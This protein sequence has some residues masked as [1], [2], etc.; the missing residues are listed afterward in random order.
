MEAF[1]LPKI[2]STKKVKA[3]QTVFTIEPLYPGYGVTIGN[4]LRRVLLSSLPGAAITAVKFSDVSHEFTTLPYVKEDVVDILLNLKQIRL[5]LHSD[6]PVTVTVKAHGAKMVTAGDIQPN[7]EVEVIDADQPIATLTDKAG[8]FEAEL[9]VAMG[10]G[11]VPVENREK[12]KLDIGTIALD[13]IYTPVKNVNFTTEH[14][15]VE[16]I[17]NFDKLLLDITTDGTISPAE[18]LQQASQIMLDHFQFVLNGPTGQDADE[19]VEAEA[20]TDE[21]TAKPKR[22]RKAKTT[23]EKAPEEEK[24][25]EQEAT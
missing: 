21:P 17:T 15:R 23:E 13:A 20:T 3:A 24:S 25:S 5:R 19:V 7:A 14:V 1:P 4:A 11:Y 18:A 16:Q 6:G 12:E 8:K 9:T 2:L 22:K 10:R